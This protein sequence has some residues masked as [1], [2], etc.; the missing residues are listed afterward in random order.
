MRPLWFLFYGGHERGVEVIRDS[1]SDNSA[2]KEYAD[3][4]ADSRRFLAD[5]FLIP[6]CGEHCDV[7]FAAPEPTWL[8]FLR[9]GD[10]V[11]SILCY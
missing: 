11:W 8:S 1:V 6:W 9:L 4:K 5:G 3:D 10:V 7:P 2:S